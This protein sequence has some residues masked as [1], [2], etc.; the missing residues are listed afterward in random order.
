MRLRIVTDRAFVL[1]QLVADDE[2][3]GPIRNRL[4]SWIPRTLRVPIVRPAPEYL[5]VRRLRLGE[6]PDEVLEAFLAAAAALELRVR[7][8]DQGPGLCFF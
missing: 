8:G 6:L 1:F 3:L 4:R 7:P 2:V 5:I